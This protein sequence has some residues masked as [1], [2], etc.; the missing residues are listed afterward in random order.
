MAGRLHKIGLDFFPLTTKIFEDDKIRFV[1]ARFEEKGE[2]I[3]VKLLQQ[4]YGHRGYYMDWNEDEAMIFAKVVGKNVTPGLVKDVVDE[5]RKREFFDKIMHK[6]FSILTSYNIQQTYHSICRDSKRKGI[7]GDQIY[8]N[9]IHQIILYDRMQGQF[10]TEE[11][12]LTPEEIELTPEEM[13]QSKVKERKENPAVARARQ[14]EKNISED[15]FFLETACMNNK[16]TAEEFTGAAAEFFSTKISTG[17]C[18]EWVDETDCRRNLM[19]SLKF[20]KQRKHNNGNKHTQ[21]GSGKI[22]APDKFPTSIQRN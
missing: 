21:G 1:G 13:Q 14:Y 3:V 15:Q 20:F 18:S 8:V 5:L 6:R 11:L 22:I 7:Y 10:K 9:P 19:F 4:I 17:E 16:I 12:Q 2:L